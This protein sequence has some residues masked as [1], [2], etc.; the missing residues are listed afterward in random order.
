MMNRA[1]DTL[2]IFGL[3]ALTGAA[4]ALL[5]A[6]QSGQETRQAI[7]RG[8]DDLVARG[9]DAVEGVGRHA[10]HAKERVEGAV[11]HMRESVRKPAE[12]VKDA[13]QSAKAA[14]NREMQGG[15]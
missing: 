11:E 5:M 3:G 7:R 12:T 13:A 6:P 9:N 1:N 14:Y 4:V 2:L 15:A 8:A 10:R